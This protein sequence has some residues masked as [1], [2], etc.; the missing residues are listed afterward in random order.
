MV[1]FIK[2]EKDEHFRQLKKGDDIFVSWNDS[3]EI[4]DKE[5]IGRKSYQILDIKKESTISEYAEEIILR[6][7]GNIF[8]TF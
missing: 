8:L 4:W 7:K 3:G 5:M 2:L 6:K 1:K